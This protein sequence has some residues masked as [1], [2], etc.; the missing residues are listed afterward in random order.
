MLD[1]YAT[2]PQLGVFKE[3]GKLELAEIDVCKAYTAALKETMRIPSLNEFD[4]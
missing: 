1:E 4:V 3:A 2:V